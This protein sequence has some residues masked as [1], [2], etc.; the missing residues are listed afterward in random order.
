M[1]TIV[2]SI[3]LIALALV[4]I[5]T[6]FI[7]IKNIISESTENTSLGKYTIRLK[8]SSVNVENQIIKVKVKREPGVANLSGIRFVVDDGQNSEI[9]DRNTTIKELEENTFTLIY[10]FLFLWDFVNLERWKMLRWIKEECQ[11]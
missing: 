4:A 7:V 11:Q 5:G 3:L 2:I 9:F 8:I 1:S 10:F 6:I